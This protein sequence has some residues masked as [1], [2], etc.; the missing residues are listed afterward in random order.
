MVNMRNQQFPV[1]MVINIG[2]KQKASI[3]IDQK[4]ERAKM[5]E[6]WMVGRRK[7]HKL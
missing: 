6:N 3:I 4:E 1:D 5:K 7:R 2:K